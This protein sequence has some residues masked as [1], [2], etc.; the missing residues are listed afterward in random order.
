MAEVD[1]TAIIDSDRP[2]SEAWEAFLW[3][4]RL[5]RREA[6]L[7]ATLAL[8]IT[9]D[10]WEV[11]SALEDGAVQSA[12]DILKTL[13]DGQP[14][15]FLGVLGEVLDDITGEAALEAVS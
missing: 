9:E 6:R 5:G 11:M 13:P 7:M 3:G 2:P 14:P 10:P 15:D 1:I 4:E 12:W 8:H